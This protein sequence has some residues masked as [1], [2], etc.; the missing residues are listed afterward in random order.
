M[1]KILKNE[2]RKL[3]SPPKRKRF[4]LMYYVKKMT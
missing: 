2:T 4:E 1:A 3:A